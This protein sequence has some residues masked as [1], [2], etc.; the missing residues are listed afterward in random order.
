M[1]INTGQRTDIP[2]FYS[3]WFI[4]RIKEGYVLVRNPFN[5]NLIT[6]FLLDP[7]VVDVIGFCTKNPRPMLAYLDELKDFGQYW[8]VSIT[9]F[10]R[11]FEPNVPPV[12]PN[13][14]QS[15]SNERIEFDLTNLP[16]EESK[17]EDVHTSIQDEILTGKN[18]IL[19]DYMREKKAEMDEWIARKEDEQKLKELEAEEN[20]KVPEDNTIS[21][22]LTKPVNDDVLSFDK[23][24]TI[25]T[26]DNSNTNYNVIDNLDLGDNSTMNEIKEEDAIQVY[27]EQ[28]TEDIELDVT[29]EDVVDDTVEEV[30]LEDTTTESNLDDLDEIKLDESS[31]K[32]D[33]G[34]VDPVPEEDKS[35]TA[36][37]IVFE[38]K[39]GIKQDPIVIEDELTPEETTSSPADSLD[40]AA[41]H[42]IELAT[43][44]LKPAAKKLDLSSFTVVKKPNTNTKG[45]D[46]KPITVAKWVLRTKKVCVHMKAAQGAE[47]EELRTLMTDADTTTDFIRLYR[48]IYDHVV[49][50]KP[51][52][53]EAWCKSTYTDDLDDY[54]FCF[55]IANYMNS[56]YIPY[57]C[58]NQNCKPGTFLSDNVPIMNMVKFNSDEDKAKFNDIYSSE[59]FDNNPDG[60]Y[61][62]ERIPF[63]DQL[64]IGFKEST[65]YS[66]IEA[67]SI[68]NNEAFINRY[69][70]TI[71]LIP[72]IDEIFKIDAENMQLIPITYKMYPESNANTYKSKV[73]K[74]DSVLRSL[75]PDEFGTLMSYINTFNEEKKNAIGIK[76]V[77][78]AATCPD[79]G[80]KIEESETTAQSLVF[81]RYQ[82]GQMVNI[83]IK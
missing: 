48:I 82:L 38:E 3:K 20:G 68:R 9:G 56:N 23:F 35:V 37:G 21:I 26:T 80:A 47:L 55:Y 41:K 7:K 12:N 75:T 60:L 66:Y 14:R 83:S 50:P 44:V 5:P 76:Y 29:V 57:D 51:T 43:K 30:E 67:Q 22:D 17:D 45:L 34:E 69:A 31:E 4:N 6:K 28:P 54:F 8:H 40:P 70:A 59:V 10:G 77:R 61:V 79:C 18:P 36:D 19:Y 11:D 62:T 32:I 24:E 46:Q 39:A 16:K 63:S 33:I 1:I 25:S 72:N 52:S 78:P 2:A 58:S 49:S 65:L 71:S 64:A 15:C 27:D 53:F 13:K 73:Q 42:L 81:F 74:Y